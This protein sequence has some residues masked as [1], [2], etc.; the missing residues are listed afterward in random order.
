LEVGSWK[1]EVRGWK[2]VLYGIFA[3][4]SASHLIEQAWP[5]YFAGLYF[6]QNGGSNFHKKS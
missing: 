4:D 3:K 6:I 1:L 2:L 5:A